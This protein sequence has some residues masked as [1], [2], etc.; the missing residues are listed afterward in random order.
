MGDMATIAISLVNTT[1][2]VLRFQLRAPLQVDGNDVVLNDIKEAT[3][4]AGDGT[5]DLEAGDYDVIF[6]GGT[7]RPISVP[8]D[9]LTYQLA[10]LLSD[11]PGSNV[12]TATPVTTY[13]PK[14][15]ITALGDLLYGTASATVAKLAG[16]TSATKK[17]LTQTGTG[18]VSAAPVWEAT[19]GD[20]DVVGP[21]S[22]TDGRPALFD[23]TTGKLIKQHTAALGGAAILNVGTSA[24]TV[25]AGDDSRIVAG[26]TALQP[27]GSG[28][29]LTGITASQVGALATGGTAADVDTA[30]TAIAA[31]L[32]LKAPLS[33]TLNTQTDSYQLVAGDAGKWVQ[34]N[35]ATANTLT[36]P[37]NATVAFA[38]GTQIVIE[39]IGAGLTSIAAAVGVTINSR[40][41]VLDSGGQFATMAL[42]KTATDTWSLS[43]DIA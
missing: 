8:D 39:Q 42:V 19:A 33:L 18:T 41:T 31:A 5:I 13:V 21:A 3:L 25:A 11:W 2:S 1:D 7:R 38:V 29:S 14:S 22:V 36:V 12:Q 28:A 10:A 23:G 37:A 6:K 20:G 4:T 9:S 27:A 15:L 16:N 43:G 34:M 26:G 32:A 24:G 35:K 40:G 30:G 17:Y